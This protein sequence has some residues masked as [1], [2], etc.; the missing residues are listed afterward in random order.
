[1]RTGGRME[2][3][4]RIHGFIAILELFGGKTVYEDA[5]SYKRDVNPQWA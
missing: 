2:L 4:R 5:Y 1:M 3:H